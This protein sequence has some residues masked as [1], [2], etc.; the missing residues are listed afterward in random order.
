M[1][2]EMYI[3]IYRKIWATVRH[4]L[5]E[6]IKVKKRELNSGS[7]VLPQQDFAECYNAAHEKFETI[8]LEIYELLMDM[9]V[10]N[11]FIPRRVMQRAYVTYATVSSK[12]PKTG[13]PIRSIW[14]DQVNQCAAQHAQYIK[15][16]EQGQFY[17]N[18][19]QDPRESPDAD[20]KIDITSFPKYGELR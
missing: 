4:E 17:S 8:R 3:R 2:A 19:G 12:D 11:E 6:S 5:H 1:T 18:I 16:F 14:A 9:K 10:D 13:Q 20:E 7:D 15:E